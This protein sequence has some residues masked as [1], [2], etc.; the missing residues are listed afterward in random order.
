MPVVLDIE[1]AHAV[2]IVG[3][4]ITEDADALIALLPETLAEAARVYRLPCRQAEFAAS[5]LCVVQTGHASNMAYNPWGKPV[6]DNGYIGISHTDGFA[7]AIASPL[8]NVAIDLEYPDPRLLRTASRFLSDTEAAWC[9]NDVERICLI[10]CC[11]EC[12]YKLY[13]RNNVEFKTEI[14]IEASGS[15]SF[16]GSI[17]NIKGITLHRI[18]L[19][20]EGMPVMVWCSRT[21]DKLMV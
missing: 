19:Q 18:L 5:R 6:V 7:A 13:G 1:A 15:Q 21:V 10:W 3:W 17:K 12:M 11:K 4:K 9:Q 2:R 14:A 8:L 20:G 16:R